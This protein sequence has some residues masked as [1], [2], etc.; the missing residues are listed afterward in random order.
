VCSSDLFGG[1]TGAVRASV[2]GRLRQEKDLVLAMLDT[3]GMNRIV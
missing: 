1:S 2:R 3:K